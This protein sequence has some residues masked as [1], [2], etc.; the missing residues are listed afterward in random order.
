M[1]MGEMLLEIDDLH[2]QFQTLDGVVRAV[3]GVT[4][5][6]RPGETVGLV[7]ESGC[8]KSVTAHSILRLLPPRTG[9]I[10][11]GA[12]RFRRR[13]GSTV[14]LAQLDP[15]GPALRSVRGNEIAMVFQEPMT[16]LSPVHTVGSQIAEAVMLHRKVNKRAARDR[17]IE[18]LA[19]VGIANP[20]Q[21]FDEY[22][23][24]FSGGMR[25]RAMIAMALSCEPSLLIAD[26]PTTA[27]DV[28]VQAQIIELLA[29]LKSQ[30]KMAMLMITHNLGL[31][32]EL[33]DRVAVMYTGKIVETASAEHLLE[34]PRHPYTVG[35][36]RSMPRL[37][38]G[39]KG[40][41]E[42]IPGSVPDPF[43]LPAGC[44][45]APRCGAEHVPACYGPER[46]PLVE[47]E[48]GHWARC[49]LYMPET[50]QP[51]APRRQEVTP[52]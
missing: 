30:L 47:V 3:D 39:V 31:I 19:R 1:S 21:R 28:T 17:A 8:G 23:H 43:H 33:A 13:D 38:A 15:R 12:I 40:R 41:L 5:A 45:F 32:A 48:P 44:T 20:A 42:A 51:T 34:Q 35:L 24:Q 52:A 26:E 9:K 6:I 22:P 46:V 27:L 49:T 2:T 7:G 10:T 4:L 16:S 11:S 50:R 25:Q 18:M 37:G 36:M 29:E 14:D